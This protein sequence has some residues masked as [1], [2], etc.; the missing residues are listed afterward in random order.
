MHPN[1]S[2]LDVSDPEVSHPEILYLV[3]VDA[4]PCTWTFQI[5]TFHIRNIRIQ[6]FNLEMVVSHMDDSHPHIRHLVIL[7]TDVS[8]LNV[9]HPNVSHL[10]ISFMDVRLSDISNAGLSHLDV[11]HLDVSQI[12]NVAY[13]DV[14]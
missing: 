11:W 10:V 9:L 6:T 4:K 12:I 7:D 8:H 13:P 2:Y 5:C 1:A 14:S 3:I